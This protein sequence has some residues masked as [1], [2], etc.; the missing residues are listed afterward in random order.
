MNRQKEL[1]FS[2]KVFVLFVVSL[3]TFALIKTTIS[4]TAQSSQAKRQ[5]DNRVPGHLPIK[6][7]IKKEKEE[8]FQ[9]LK[10]ERWIRDFELEVRNTGERPIYALSVAWMLEE[11]KMPNGNP[12]GAIFRYGRSEFITNP[13]ETPKPEDIP[14]QPGETHLFKLS[15]KSVEGWESWARDNKLPPPKS[16]QIIFDWVSFGDG[17]GWE[18]PG[19]KAFN[20][21]KPLAF[22]SPNRAGPGNCEQ[23]TRQ[24]ERALP[25]D[26]S[27]APASFAPV[28]F[29]FKFFS[30]QRFKQCS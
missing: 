2:M 5:L 29:F 6:V 26:L 25:L 19:G 23:Q 11:V 17:T 13:G 20:R 16:I 22:A 30:C 9:D 1:S 18:G 4:T 14:I 10:N 24:R 7:K 12:Y 15:A 21:R 27:I 8:N 28:N 3:F